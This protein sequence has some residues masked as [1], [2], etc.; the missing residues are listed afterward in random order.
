MNVCIG[1]EY[2][3]SDFGA[4]VSGVLKLFEIK[5][6]KLAH[7]PFHRPN[8]TMVL[9]WSSFI[10]VLVGLSFCSI[11]K[12]QRFSTSKTRFRKRLNQRYLYR[13]F[14]KYRP[15][16][17]KFV[18][19]NGTHRVSVSRR[20]LKLNGIVRAWGAIVA[21]PTWREDSRALAFIKRDYRHGYVLVV[22]Q[23]HDGNE[24]HPHRRFEDQMIWKVPYHV[25]KKPKLTW[26]TKNSIGIGP[27]L[28]KPKVVVSWTTTLAQR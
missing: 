14:K 21:R 18:S 2:R 5:N 23:S 19:P 28:F 16:A 7:A 3:G 24:F 20:G 22:L 13:S 6:E 17:K 27:S 10:W 11:G 15:R 8:E 4:K 12:A 26:L 9:R 25:G 1:L